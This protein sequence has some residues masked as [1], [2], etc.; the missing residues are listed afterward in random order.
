[1]P[2]LHCCD[3]RKDGQESNVKGQIC[4]KICNDMYSWPYGPVS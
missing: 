1:M 2:C 3:A 4:P